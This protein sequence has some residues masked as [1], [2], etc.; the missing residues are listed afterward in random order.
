MSTIGLVNNLKNEN[1]FEIK[2]DENNTYMIGQYGPVIK[3]VETVDGKEIT[4]FKKINKDANILEGNIDDIVQ[5]TDT[6]ASIG[7]GAGT[8]KSPSF[9]N[10]GKY[11]NNDVI[12]RKGKY[13]L[14]I[15]WGES[16]TRTLKELGNRPMESITFDEIQKYLK[17]GNGL[18]REISSSMS[19]RNGPKGDYIFYKKSNMKTP[20]FHS[21]NGF[22]EDY[23][24]CDITILKSWI[25][26][27]Y[28]V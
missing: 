3:C 4:T 10:L 11:E 17:Q 22:K 18:V 21:L 15:S 16:N 23:K 14:Y 26:D 5:K 27:T 19:I 12:L 13:G 6:G 1:K 20:K 9:I 28:G 25:N 7:T 8:D 24:I 2:I